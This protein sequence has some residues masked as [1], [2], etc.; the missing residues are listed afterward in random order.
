MDRRARRPYFF[1]IFTIVNFIVIQALLWRMTRAPLATLLKMFVVLVPGFAVQ[2]AIGIGVRAAIGPRE[3]YLRLIRTPEWLADTARI[4]VFSAFSVQ[5]YCWI[6]IAIPLLHPR[7]F[8]QELWNI[9]R[10][11]FFGMSPNILFVDLFGSPAALRFV[12]WSYANVFYASLF[13]AAAFFASSPDRS[14]RLAFTDSNIA[15]WI[16]GAWL[17]VLVPSLGPAFRFPEVW[18]PL[19][20]MFSNTQT[21]QRL[22]VANYTTVLAYRQGVVRSVNILFG[23]AAFPSLHV[24]FEVLV[25]LW[26]RRLWR[27]GTAIFGIFTVVIFIGSIITGWHYLI[28]GLAGALLATACYVVAMRQYGLAGKRFFD[29]AATDSGTDHPR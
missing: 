15:M 7:L 10:M 29:Y 12:D 1:E 22:L 11:L 6:K 23:I 24:A 17:Y 16:I 14:V 18:L 25:L 8:D 28:D 9:D 27:Y 21:L 2:A 5:T 19:Q 20:Q 3:A 13:V 4:I 26:M